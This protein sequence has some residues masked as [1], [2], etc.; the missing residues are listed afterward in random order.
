MRKYQ[1]GAICRDARELPPGATLW[2]DGNARASWWL[3]WDGETLRSNAGGDG[4][5]YN[6]TNVNRTVRSLPDTDL[7]VASTKES[8]EDVVNHPKHYAYHSFEVITVLKEAFPTD[9]LLWQVGKYLLRA[10]NKGKELEDLKKAQFY[11]EAK[12]AELSQ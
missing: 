4:T 7:A 9:P 12:I 6:L 1:V 3:A 10:K 8:V 11:L 5:A 2:P